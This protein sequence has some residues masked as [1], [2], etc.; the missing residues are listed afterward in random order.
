[1][2]R[3]F[4]VPLGLLPSATDPTGHTAGETYYNTTFNTIK[5]YDG[6]AWKSAGSVTSI[7]GGIPS[8]TYVIEFDGGT[9]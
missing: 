1:M 3:K 7:D 8:D 9:P 6:A 5:T 4:V 2:A